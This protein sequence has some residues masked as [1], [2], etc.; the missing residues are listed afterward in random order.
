MI[1]GI[2]VQDLRFIGESDRG[3][4]YEFDCDRKGP[5]TVGFRKA[6]SVNGRHYHEGLSEQ[7]NPE[8]FILLSGTMD[9]YAKNLLTGEEMRNA[10]HA[11]IQLEIHP[12]V[13]HEIVAVTDI[14]FIELNSIA[15]HSKDTKYAA[16]LKTVAEKE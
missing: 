3:S 9:V 13:W 10:Y 4:T 16:D 8:I 11:P 14:T 6:G 5:F 2:K 7:K 12:N 15:E 1:S